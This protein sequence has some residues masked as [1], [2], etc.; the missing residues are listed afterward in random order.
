MNTTDVIEPADAGRASAGSLPPS[1]QAGDRGAEA[2]TGRRVIA[3]LERYALVLLLILL[4]IVFSV[5]PATSDTFPTLANLRN[6]AAN[7]SVV[8]I[9]ALGALVPLVAH[10]FDVS[11]GATLGLAAIAAAELTTRGGF[12][13]APALLV[14]ALVGLAIGTVNGTLIARFGANSLVITL[15]MATLVGGIGAWWSRNDTILGVPE[16]L[17]TFGNTNWLGVPKPVWLLIAVALLV[18]YLLRFTVFGRQLLSIGSNPE[19]A[20]LVGM[21][22]TRCVLIAFAISGA[23]AAVAGLLLLARTGGATAGVGD[24]YTLPA[25]AAVFLGSTTIRPGRFTVAGTL[26]GVFFVAVSVNGLT[27]AGAADWVEP[28]FN[29]AAVV[30][31]VTASAILVRR[32]G[33]TQS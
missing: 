15:G 29:G 17:T 3:T 2:S 5:L 6:I 20:R 27:L 21:P 18:T 30:I 24:G 14:G 23:I 19:A 12:A 1:S 31:A 9:A 33:G 13:L 22:V 7:E 10:Q 25:L 32:R 11:V 8:A 4:V 26:V 28:V 16:W